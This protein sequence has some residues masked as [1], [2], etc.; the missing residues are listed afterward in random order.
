MIDANTRESDSS[1]CP[2]PRTDG[3]ANV[4][5]GDAPTV[6]AGPG[7]RAIPGVSFVVCTHNGASRIVTTLAHLAAQTSSEI[8]SEVILVDNA[9]WDNTKGLALESWPQSC[10]IPLRVV[11]EPQLGLSYARE[12]GL[13]EASYEIVSFV[14]DDNWVCDQWAEIVVEVMT[15]HP[16]AAAC[17]GFAQAICEEPPPWWF[18]RFK[19][20]F[21]I[22]PD[23]AQEADVTEGATVLWGAGLTVRKSAWLELKRRGFNFLLPDRQGEAL[24]EGGDTELCC[25]LRLAGWRL[26]YVPRLRLRHFL[27]KERVRWDHLRARH[28]A[29]G[30]S[31]VG[32]DPYY[33]ALRRTRQSF[34]VRSLDRLQ[35][36]WKWQAAATAAR[37]L[38]RRPVGLLLLPMRGVEGKKAVLGAEFNVGRLKKLCQMRQAYD[39]TIRRVRSQWTG[40][41]QRL[42][43]EGSQFSAGPE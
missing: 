18:E 6:G 31:S 23:L 10:R 7:R 38:A 36:N 30:V 29:G 37:L 28:R 15:E 20:G 40:A 33:F 21:A 32:L 41:C 42:Q 24:T 8:P 39:L 34:W 25:A 9:S 35:A 13:R 4:A 11:V 43:S 22:G 16:E 2:K 1:R 26:R 19:S 12:R 27:P 5:A 17:G 3:T 14:D